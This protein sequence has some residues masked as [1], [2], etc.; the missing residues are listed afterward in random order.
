MNWESIRNLAHRDDIWVATSYRKLIDEISNLPHN[1]QVTMQYCNKNKFSGVLLVDWKYVKVKWYDKKIPFIYWMDYET[2][3][4]VV[5][6]LAPTENHIALKHFFTILRNTSYKLR[7]VVCDDNAAIA[8]AANE[9]FPNT[10]VQ[11]CHVH[12]LEN[13][14][15]LLKTRTEEKYQWFVSQLKSKLFMWDKK[16]VKKKK[17]KKDLHDLLDEWKDDEMAA[18]VLININNHID[19][20]TNHLKIWACPRTTNLIES[21]NKQLNWRLKTIQGFQTFQSAEKWLSAWALN[22]RL[23]KMTC[24]RNK[25]KKLNGKCSLEITKKWWIDLPKFF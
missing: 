13:I 3:D 25:F 8:M 4:I 23:T 10:L 15:K 12:F 19:E 18:W 14:R 24:C 11:L 20:L 17:I 7:W 9:L 21:Y 1:N 22:R 2:H 5:C 16:K 6:I